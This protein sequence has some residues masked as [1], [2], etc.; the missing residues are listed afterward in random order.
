[1]QDEKL[2]QEL[3]A[4]ENEEAV[5]DA[6]NQHG[7]LTDKMRWRDVGDQPNNQALVNNQQSSPVAALVEKFTNGLDAILLRHCK[8]K[9]IDPRGSNAPENMANAVQQFFGELSEKETHE[10]RKI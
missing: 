3:L 4:A 9:K 6:L 10:I 7:L 2:L 5:L 1:M 8:E